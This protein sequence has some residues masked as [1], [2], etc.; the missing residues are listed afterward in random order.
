MRILPVWNIFAHSVRSVLDNIRF[1]F[2]ISWPWMLAILPVH[3][4]SNVFVAMNPPAEGQPYEPRVM[5][6]IFISGLA[7]MIAFSSIAVSWHR[8]ILLDQV[9]QGMQ[10]LR[11]DGT[12]WRYLGNTILIA[13]IVFLGSL[14][15]GFVIGFVAALLGPAAP[16]VTVP[17]LFVLSGLAVSYFYRM[18]VKLPAIAL[19][20]QDYMIRNALN[21]TQGNTLRFVVLFLLVLAIVL[22]IASV[23]A[24][25]NYVVTGIG[26]GVGLYVIIA[27]QLVLNW[28][29]T[30]WGVTMLTSLY[31]FFAEGRDV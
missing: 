11:L 14:I 13:L 3:V 26:G 31:G 25:L 17:A 5:A 2:H 23:L 16:F 29:A 1:A 19:E 30:V 27:L 10:R 4:A 21:D 8:Y 28:I 22:T 7:S 12:V 24:G 18:S 15:P 20:R 9:P 6:A